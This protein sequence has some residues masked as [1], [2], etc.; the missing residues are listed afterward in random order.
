MALTHGTLTRTAMADAAVDRIDLGAGAGTLTFKSALDATICV[1][2]LADPAFGAAS[3][4]S[5]TL[6]GV[7][8][9]GT[10]TASG[11]ITKFTIA[12]SNAVAIINGTVGTSG[13]DINLSSVSVQ[14]NDIIQIDAITYTASA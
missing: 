8:L 5:A 11:T 12:D 7:P 4:G 9:Q 6:L 2:T 13:A 14:L 10:V 3:G 1:V